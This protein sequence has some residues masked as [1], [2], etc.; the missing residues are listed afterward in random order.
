MCVLAY[1]CAY[2]SSFPAAL[3]SYTSLLKREII[4]VGGASARLS[5]IKCVWDP[6]IHIYIY[7]YIYASHECMIRRAYLD[8]IV[9]VD[10]II[11]AL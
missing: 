11:S 2:V 3:K 5:T 6:Y 7:M 4:Y 8:E 1:V 10:Y 9:L